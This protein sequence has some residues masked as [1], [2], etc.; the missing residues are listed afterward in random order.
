MRI[1]AAGYMPVDVVQPFH[2][3]SF[4]SIGGTSANVA[5]ILGYFGWRAELAGQIG[6]DPLAEEFLREATRVGA[7]TRFV[8][9]ANG[10]ET[11]RILHRV[12]PDGHSYGYTCPSCHQRFPRSRP[13]TLEIA[14]EVIAQ[15]RNVNIFMF[16]RVNAGTVAL[17]EHFATRRT[18]VVFE[19]SLPTGGPLFQR[20]CESADVIKHSADVELPILTT[21]PSSRPRQLRVVTFGAGG[22]SFQFGSSALRHLDAIPTLTVDTAGAGDWT[23]AA[24]ILRACGP[25][26][27]D[28]SRVEAGL[29]LGQAYAALCCSVVGARSLT[30]IDRRVLARLARATLATN[31][32]NSSFALPLPR[33]ENPR[34]TRCPL[35]DLQV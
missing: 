9:R 28:E 1:L 23:T 24:L 14:N 2:G 20:A 10:A 26:G 32:L 27:L 7:A 29:R 33:K 35:C 19:P 16:D 3:D 34:P 8:R 15:L 31:A 22:L 11:A 21:I 25:L 13:L 30:Q 18:I 4:R 5:L 12:G 17:A 6:D